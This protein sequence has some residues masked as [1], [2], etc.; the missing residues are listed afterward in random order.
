[1]KKLYFALGL[2]LI[3]ELLMGQT[4]KKDLTEEEKR[5]I[6]N[7]GTER[8]FT[9][10]YYDFKGKGTYVCKQCG[11]PLFHSEDKFDSGCGWPSFDE[12]IPK[13]VKRL[14]DADDRRTEIVCA[15]CGGHLGHVF[16]GEG[17]TPKNTRHCVNSISMDFVLAGKGGG[18]TE[19]GEKKEQ[20]ETAIFAG[21]CFWGV[22]YLMEKQPGVLSVVSGYIGGK[23]SHPT[24]EQVCSKTTGHAEAVRIVFDPSKVS[25][26][27]LAKLFFEIHDPTQLNRQGPDVGDQYRS[28]VF[29]TTPEQKQIAEKLIAQLK[30]KGYSVVTKV[31]SATTFWPAETY[32]QDYYDR[33][34]TTPYCHRYT[35]RF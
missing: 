17:L 15:N 4:M 16:V 35:K 19:T 7:K 30:T 2:V 18:Q 28:E 20:T 1:M 11:A 23:V 5:V 8:P 9:G 31:T 14:P 13:A 26:E 6:L 10:K 29:Y 12:E 27:T 21:G 33:K 34:G 3:V 25:Y 22:E 32:H 24:Y